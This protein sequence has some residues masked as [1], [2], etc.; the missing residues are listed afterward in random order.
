MLSSIRRSEGRLWPGR[1]DSGDLPLLNLLLTGLRNLLRLLARLPASLAPLLVLVLALRLRF[2][3]LT[4]EGLADS[5]ESTTLALA[6]KSSLSESLDTE[7]AGLMGALACSASLS[8]LLAAG[9]AGKLSDGAGDST[10]TTSAFLA[11]GLASESE[12][13]V[14]LGSGLADS[15]LTGMTFL[16]D[17]LLGFSLSWSLLLLLLLPLSSAFLRSLLTDF[18]RSLLT[19]FLRSL[20]TE[21]LR[22]GLLLRD[23]LRFGLLLKDLLRFGLRL[24]ERLRLRGGVEGLRRLRGGVWSLPLLRASLCLK[25]RG[26]LPRLRGLGRLPLDLERLAGERLLGE[27][28]RLDLLRKRLDLLGDRR[29]LLVLWRLGLSGLAALFLLLG[30]GDLERALALLSEEAGDLL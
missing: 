7:T 6:F 9:L 25:D 18:L 13:K 17:L 30:F 15:A 23:L 3:R 14:F 2:F 16:A 12:E 5:E 19:D 4:G 24:M 8:E 26:L 1:K 21:F 11:G 28:R 27:D 22:L 10:L 20:L 29:R